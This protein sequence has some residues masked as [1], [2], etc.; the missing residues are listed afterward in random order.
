MSLMH[1]AE[2]LDDTFE[3]EAALPIERLVANTERV[4]SR[5]LPAVRAARSV[6]VGSYFGLG[7]AM[8]ELYRWIVAEGHA[9][10]GP[11]REVFHVTPAD[12]VLPD[13]YRTEILWPVA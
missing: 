5:E 8:Q 7:R 2:W 13:A 11:V 12:T 1:E 10:S 6:Y 3:F 4:T 9:A